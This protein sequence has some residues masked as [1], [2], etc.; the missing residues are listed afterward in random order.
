MKAITYL[1][2]FAVLL[3]ACAPV[4]HPASPVAT[5][6]PTITIISTKT[7]IP[8]ITPMSIP[9]PF[10]LTKGTTWVYSFETYEAS[11]TPGHVVNAT[12]Q[13]TETVVETKSIPPYF[14]AHIKIDYK[15]VTVEDGWE[16]WWVSGQPAEIWFVA[17][18]QQVFES[19]QPINAV[20]TNRLVLD[21]QFP[22][23]AN[24]AWC[25][26]GNCEQT[27]LGWRS[28]EN[29]SYFK[30]STATF[31]DCY[32]MLD[33]YNGGGLFHTFCNGVGIVSM[34]FDHMGTPYGFKQTLINYSIG[35]P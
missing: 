31:D 8:T 29:Q 35:V 30:T 11:N 7:S 6:V 22:L 16:G 1:L 21:Y 24:S 34:K 5:V 10:P 32:D 19:H 17:D 18:N 9:L 23:S 27:G 33:H 25:Q 14:I 4:Q 20:E 26:G 15:L 28:V 3:G 12:Y 13:L 2:F